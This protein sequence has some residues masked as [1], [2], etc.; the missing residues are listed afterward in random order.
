MRAAG[1]C[2]WLKPISERGDG[3]FQKAVDGLNW[4]AKNKFDIHIAGQ[5][6]FANTEENAKAGYADLIRQHNWHI[7]ASNPTHVMLFP[8]MGEQIDVPE[9]TTAC[10][11][12]LNVHPHTMM[13]ATSRMVVRRKGEDVPAVLACTLL[14]DD[15]QFETGKTLKDSLGPIALNHPHC[16]KFCVLGGTSCSA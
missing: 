14:W 4:L 9:I 13:C 12:I 16:A 2:G 3:S 15:V 10:W 11:G 1:A 6:S 7:D 5:A 8:E